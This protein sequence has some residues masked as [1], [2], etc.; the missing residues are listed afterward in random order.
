[1]FTEDK[2]ALDSPPHHRN[3]A[4]GVIF[5]LVSP[6]S[7]YTLDKRIRGVVTRKV[8]NNHD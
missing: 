2:Q 7:P 4:L 3:P 8:H 1:M 5:R 6:Q